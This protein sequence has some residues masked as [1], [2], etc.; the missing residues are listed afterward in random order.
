[1]ITQDRLKQLLHYNPDTGIFTRLKANRKLTIG[2]PC[3]SVG[4]DNRVMISIDNKNYRAH[5]LAW[6]YIYGEFPE[7]EIDHINGNA[8][9]NR[10]CNLRSVSHKVNLQNRVSFT[11]HNSVKYIGVTKNRNRY[12]AQIKI[13]GVRVWLGTYDTPEEASEVYLKFKRQYHEGCTI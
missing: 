8:S 13:D 7:L 11:K 2:S 12:G 5:R 10:I 9:D 6:L 4:K 1:M 3:G